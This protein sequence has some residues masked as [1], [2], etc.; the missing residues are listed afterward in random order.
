LHPDF[1]ING[2][3]GIIAFTGYRGLF[4]YRIQNTQLPDIANVKANIKLL[5][6]KLK[7]MGWRFAS[8]SWSHQAQSAIEENKFEAQESQW[9]ADETPLLG[10]VDLYITPLGSP[11]EPYKERIKW[12]YS[13]GFHFFFNVGYDSSWS[14]NAEGVH[15][16]RIP[17]DGRG[18]RA[19]NRV[20]NRLFDVKAVIDP[21]RPEIKAVTAKVSPT[22]TPPPKQF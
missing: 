6:D 20:L 7:S 10:P 18:L 8:H 11:L 4:G 16:D 13:K 21:A 3:R 22:P 19:H 5:A 2:A 9:I 14:Y 17:I 15:M 1:S 12:L